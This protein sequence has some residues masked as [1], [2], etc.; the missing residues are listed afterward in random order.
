MDIFFCCLGKI[1]SPPDRTELIFLPGS[2]MNITWTFNDSPPTVTSRSWYFT[3]Y[4]AL[5]QGE[6]I[7]QITGVGAGVRKDILPGLD[8]IE[9][10]TLSLSNVNQSYDGTYQF[11]LGASTQITPIISRVIVYIASKSHGVK[12]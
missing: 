3:S 10:A 9:P 4:S 1:T 7:A 8:L 6:L 12:M 5:V 11:S 2:S